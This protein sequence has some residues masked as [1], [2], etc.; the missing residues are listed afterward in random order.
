MKTALLFFFM[1]TA[2][3]FSQFSN[4]AYVATPSVE[5]LSGGTYKPLTMPNVT[6]ANFNA[7]GKVLINGKLVNI[8][9]YVPPA[10]TAAQAAKSSLW[11]NPWLVGLSLLTWAGD[12]GLESDGVDWTK[13]TDPA[14]FKP[15]VNPLNHWPAMSPD[16]IVSVQGRRTNNGCPTNGLQEPLAVCISGYAAQDCGSSPCS[17]CVVYP[18]HTGPQGEYVPADPAGVYTGGPVTGYPSGAGYEDV[19]NGCPAGYAGGSAT[20]D[21]LLVDPA[22]A[23]GETGPATEADFNALPD[24]PVP[25]LA[26]LAPQVGVPVGDPF[27]IGQDLPVGQPYTKPDGSTVEPRARVSPAGDGQV[28]IDTYEKPLT[29]AQG[30]PIADPVPQDTPDVAPTE[31]ECDKFPSSLGCSNL[32]QPSPESLGTEN[33]NISLIAPVSIGAAGA[34][35]APLTASFLGQA[36]E[37][38]FDPLCDYANA[39]RPLVLSLAWLSAGIIFIGGVRNG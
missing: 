36:V 4:A 25:A 37:F 35:P 26:E 21:C 1:L 39:L 7:T 8:P 27:Y 30:N 38:S 17:C 19:Q 3:V 29:D 11:L 15:W 22:L 24:P 18:A 14:P 10:S 23:Q 9:G 32:D 5:G 6:G 31:S 33:R 16:G 20:R 2:L 13:T 34:C 12:A 28:T